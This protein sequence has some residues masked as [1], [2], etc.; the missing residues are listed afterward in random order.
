MFEIFVGVSCMLLL[1]IGGC[2]LLWDV[3]PSAFLFSIG[4]DLLFFVFWLF[5]LLFWFYFVFVNLNHFINFFLRNFE[6]IQCDLPKFTFSLCIYLSRIL[7][8]VVHFNKITTFVAMTI[9]LCESM[10]RAF[11]QMLIVILW[12]LDE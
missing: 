12:V 7:P 1:Q 10:Y 9:C 3:L 2:W 4:I 6:F 5:I 11:I 8:L